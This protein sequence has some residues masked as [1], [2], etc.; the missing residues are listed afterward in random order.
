MRLSEFMTL[1]LAAGAPFCAQ[2]FLQHGRGQH[3][4]LTILKA[5]CAMLLWPL[6]LSLNLLTRRGRAGSLEVSIE[7]A[8]MRRTLER[9]AQA[10]EGLLNALYRIEEL[11]REVSSTQ[12]C[13]RVEQETRAVSES[14]EKYVGLTL[15]ASAADFNG[16]PDEREMELCRIAG[17]RGDDLLLAG[18]C[19]HRRNAVQLV[20]HQAR[21]RTELLHA[22]ANVREFGAL[23]AS[24][25]SAASNARMLAARYLSVAVIKFYGHAINLLSLLEDESAAKG[26]ARLL[27][28]ECARLRRLESDYL[29]DAAEN[30]AEGEVCTTG[31][32]SN[33]APQTL[34]QT[35]AALR[36]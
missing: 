20:S 4:A 32:L 7:D 10:K 11:A 24:D 16:P 23:D 25:A 14:I 36:S 27:N 5:T 17:R 13:G 18:L 28:A 33:T 1:Y 12:P 30:A 29:P 22:L 26:A 21:S 31:H 6:S 34:R 19:M 9:A 15:A 2:H 35:R 3:R 8:A